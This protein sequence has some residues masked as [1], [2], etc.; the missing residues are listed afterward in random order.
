MLFSAGELGR[1]GL[2]GLRQ[3]PHGRQNEVLIHG[4]PP[5]RCR[6]RKLC[7]WCCTLKP[8]HRDKDYTTSVAKLPLRMRGRPVVGNAVPAWVVPASRLHC[9]TAQQG[10][11]HALICPAG[12][13]ALR[14]QGF[15]LPSEALGGKCVHRHLCHHLAPSLRA[16]VQPGEEGLPGEISTRKHEANQALGICAGTTRRLATETT[17]S[18]ERGGEKKGRVRH[19]LNPMQV[20]QQALMR[21]LRT[22]EARRDWRGVLAAMDS[23]RNEQVPM[24][25]TIY[26]KAI[27]AIAKSGSR[28]RETLAWVE[29][30][31]SDGLSPD[32]YSYAGCID[33]CAKAAQWKKACQI[34]GQMRE[35]GVEPNGY[36]FNS[37]INAC[38]KAHKWREALALLR[39]MEREGVLVTTVTL[40][41][42]V[43]AC[44]IAGEWRTSLKML[45][46]MQSKGSPQW[47]KPN[48]RTF[49][50]AIKACAEAAEWKTA[51][52]LLAQLR[53][54]Q[55]EEGGEPLDADTVSFN[56]TINALGRGGEWEKAVALLREMTRAGL[57]VKP[58]EI[59][60]NSAIHACGRGGQWKLAL[61]LLK[62]M[63]ELGLPPDRISFGA[64]ANALGKAGEWP[65]LLEL[66]E[67]MKVDGNPPTN[68]AFKA[69]VDC[70]SK[71]GEWQHA[72]SLIKWMRAT[73]YPPTVLTL[74]SVMS[75]CGRSGR[76]E[77]ALALLNETR[78]HGPSATASIYVAAAQACARAG[79]WEEAIDLMEMMKVDGVRPTEKYYMALLRATGEGGRTDKT[80]E[81]LE[82]MKSIG[83]KP[84]VRSYNCAIG[85]CGK[86]GSWKRAMT[87]LAEMYVKGM[88]PAGF[89]VAATIRACS[90]AGEWTK[91]LEVLR[92]SQQVEP[93]KP[94]PC[95][96]GAA[97]EMCCRAGELEH[98]RAILPHLTALAGNE[99][100]DGWIR[101][102]MTIL[103]AY[104]G[105]GDAS[106][107]VGI[108]AANGNDGPKSI[109]AHERPSRTG[110][111]MHHT[112]SW[113]EKHSNRSREGR[114]NL[115]AGLAESGVTFTSA[116]PD[117]V[118]PTNC[119]WS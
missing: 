112:P 22:L 98:A 54:G 6:S 48:S 109:A 94:D 64:M 50:I 89:A 37:A 71:A 66:L 110:G 27:I 8:S 29:N 86:A 84:G 24:S 15:N 23:A 60:Y 111:T 3:R 119:R 108:K 44:G 72:V 74:S 9:E 68:V 58:N 91:G 101:E 2:D 76:W 117:E 104:S 32:V 13:I 39:Q 7:M 93:P 73:G 103:S 83:L 75:A 17:S 33:A 38:G 45:E 18:H 106:D 20:Q 85:A 4:A 67:E 79:K 96:L 26:N 16:G 30:M 51:L 114:P 10:A 55:A 81:I 36:A 63:R 70:C 118:R 62:E 5:S 115:S 69:A 19:R 47:Q 87:L 28:W 25:R 12:R 65:L 100:A 102:T 46:D 53:A 78:K 95:S 61:S 31:K 80:L 35:A 77:V 99:G 59:S 52:Q 42:T 40:N 92:R 57:G 116:S 49:N 107:D 88:R 90:A 41:A 97:I 14:S 113:R 1:E 34:L 11:V 43:D 56:A 21:R 82:E 105:N